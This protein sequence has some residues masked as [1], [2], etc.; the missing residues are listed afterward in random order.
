MLVLMPI[1]GSQNVLVVAYKCDATSDWKTMAWTTTTNFEECKWLFIYS[2]NNADLF[3]LDQSPDLVEN[4]KWQ[5][6]EAHF[7]HLTKP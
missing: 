2:G 4:A 3:D 5:A 6:I 1:R 7:N